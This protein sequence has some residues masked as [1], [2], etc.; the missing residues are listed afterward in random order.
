MAHN[1]P[2]GVKRGVS[3]YC[4]DKFLYANMDMEDMFRDMYDMGATGLE[5]L[6]D[7]VIEGYP[8]PSNAWLDKFF[9][10]TER[11]NIV[12]VEYGHWVESRLFPDRDGTVE[13]QAEMLIHDI[14]LAHQMGFTCMRTKLGVI[15]ETLSPYTEWREIIR[16]ALP[17][18]EKYDVRMQPEIHAPTL[19]KDPMMMDY[20]EFIDKEQTKYF[21][22]NIDFGVF[23]NVGAMHFPGQDPNRPLWSEPEDIVPL[24]PYIYCCHAKFYDMN[25]EFDEVTIPYKK[26]VQ[27]MID[28]GWDGYLLSEY[29]GKNKDNMY[30]VQT[31]LRR[32]QVLLKNLIG[33]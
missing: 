20:C 32:H 17:Y 12:P 8:Y 9:A 4:Y 22:F 24:L 6:A 18:A 13:E 5:I 2:K 15:D 27:L 23:K 30:H 31:Q 19:L 26:V 14:K 25:E 11:Y 16:R 28:N 3:T 21:G 10:L 7:G 33:F 29:E 1:E